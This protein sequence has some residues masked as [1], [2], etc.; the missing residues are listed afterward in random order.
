MLGNVV[1]RS[2]FFLAQKD[3]FFFGVVNPLLSYRDAISSEHS[4]EF[5]RCISIRKKQP[6]C[7]SFGKLEARLVDRYRARL[8]KMKIGRDAF[9]LRAHWA[10][11]NPKTQH[12][13]GTFH[14]QVGQECEEPLM[15][16]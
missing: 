14:A 13:I 5:I 12:P 4:A 8:D 3:T 1:E 2:L 10:V 16:Q 7:L 15:G 9:E 6:N 11:L